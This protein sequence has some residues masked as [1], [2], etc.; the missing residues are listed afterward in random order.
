MHQLHGGKKKEEQRQLLFLAA[1][2]THLLT[3][4][5]VKT[6]PALQSCKLLLL[7]VR[8]VRAW[9]PSPVSPSLQSGQRLDQQ[10]ADTTCRGQWGKNPVCLT[11][12]V[13]D[14]HTAQVAQS[15]FVVWGVVPNDAVILAAEVVKPT[16]YGCHTRQI[17]QH[18]L[19]LLD[20]FLKEQ[21]TF[22]NRK[23]LQWGWQQSIIADC[24]RCP[25]GVLPKNNSISIRGTSVL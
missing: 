21:T 7:R 14:V 23:M 24:L 1:W 18:F 16:V 25:Q 19:D 10:V 5:R 15:V 4:V 2:G 12:E 11:W 17:I 20:Q 9:T 3:S 22:L 8:P 13:S 6:T